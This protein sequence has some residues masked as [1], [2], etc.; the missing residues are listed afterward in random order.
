MKLAMFTAALLSV[1]VPVSAQTL[2]YDPNE[3]N[4]QVMRNKIEFSQRE[5]LSGSIKVALIQGLRD[6]RS[7]IKRAL[8][9]CTTD[10]YVRTM[11]RAMSISSGQLWALEEVWV[12]DEMDTTPGV[13]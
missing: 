6:R 11:A 8:Q 7:V 13:R 2:Q 4:R 1:A 5:C 9:N 10:A 12:N 3:A